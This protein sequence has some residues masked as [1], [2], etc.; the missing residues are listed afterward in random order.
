MKHVQSLGMLLLVTALMASSAGNAQQ[1]SQGVAPIR[2]D[3]LGST[4]APDEGALRQ[5]VGSATT[6]SSV[7]L[8]NYPEMPVSDRLLAGLEAAGRVLT[9]ADGQ[10]ITWGFKHEEA[11]LQSVVIADRAGQLELAVVV[12]DVVR[13]KLDGAKA[14]VSVAQYRG[15]VARLGVQP[16]V[17]VFARDPASL[18]KAYPLLMRWLQA[19]L[20]GFN[21]SCAKHAAS[22]ALLPEIDLP[23]DAYLSPAAGELP[24]RT[25]LPK[26]TVANIPLAEFTL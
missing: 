8:L 15:R 2:V 22:C 11:N 19:D 26:L 12:D 25:A 24:V 16:R 4:E 13:L 7:Q 6:G 18:E 20:L 14:D 10:T 23:T 1:A 5:L 3:A 17:V 21:T 9:A